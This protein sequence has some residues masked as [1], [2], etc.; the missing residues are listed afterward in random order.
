M[1]R[2]GKQPVVLPQGV[3]ASFSDGQLA[4]TGPKGSLSQWVDSRV[5]VEVDGDKKEVRFSRSN[6]EAES[7][8]LHGLYRAL[9]QNININ[10]LAE[11]LSKAN[12]ELSGGEVEEV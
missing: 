9:A 12:V 11:N 1:S 5:T 6:D 3:E 10:Q 2:I 4:V 8:A 7:R